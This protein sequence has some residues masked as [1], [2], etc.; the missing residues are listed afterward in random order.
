LKYATV[1]DKQAALT[2]IPVAQNN[3]KI[4]NNYDDDEEL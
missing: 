2:S 1:G 4:T 3:A